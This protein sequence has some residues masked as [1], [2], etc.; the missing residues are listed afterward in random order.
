M[1]KVFLVLVTVSV[2]AGAAW[3][4]WGRSGESSA[5]AAGT[6]LARPALTVELGSASRGAMADLVTVVGSLEGEATVEVSSKVNGRL[7]EVVVRI[8]DRVAKGALLARVEAREIQEQVNQAQASFEVARATVK[9]READ[10]KFAQTS[11]DRSRHLFE[12]ELLPRQTLD[13]VDARQ[14]ASQAQLELARAQFMLAKA[15]L[16]EQKITLSSTEIRSPV[17][18]FV[19]KRMLD[20]GAFV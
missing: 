7:E 20:P 10:L 16:D 5:A 19:G 12:R 14:Q 8:G 6:A 3:V 13:D 1:K 18:G 17:N 2:L 11:L 9:Q 4:V 15:R